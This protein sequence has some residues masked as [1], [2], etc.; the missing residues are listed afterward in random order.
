MIACQVVDVAQQPSSV[1]KPATIPPISG[2]VRWP[3]EQRFTCDNVQSTDT[4]EHRF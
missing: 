1:P 2:N 3:H 4:S